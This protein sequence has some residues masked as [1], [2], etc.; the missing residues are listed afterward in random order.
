MSSV[1][2][3]RTLQLANVALDSLLIASEGMFEQ[4]DKEQKNASMSCPFFVA[5]TSSVLH[6]TAALK[7]G[8]FHPVH[9]H[10]DL[11]KER[12]NGLQIMMCTAKRY[13]MNCKTQQD[14][15]ETMNSMNQR[16]RSSAAL[17]A[18]ASNH[19]PVLCPLPFQDVFGSGILALCI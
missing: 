10:H 9:R 15:L 13:L 14:K 2:V 4:S 11:A 7:E 5:C 1:Q 18:L 3:K 16:N 17:S 19:P 8:C 12:R 6:R